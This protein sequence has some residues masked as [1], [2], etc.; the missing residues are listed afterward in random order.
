MSSVSGE[1]LV[2]EV[3]CPFRNVN[4]LNPMGFNQTD[5]YNAEQPALFL[6]DTG[7][8]LYLWQ[9]FWPPSHSP[10]DNSN[11]ITG[12]GMIRWHAERRAA[13]ATIVQYRKLSYKDFRK[14]PDAELVWA[15]CEPDKFTNLFPSWTHKPEVEKVNRE[16]VKDN[17]LERTLSELSKSEYTWEELQQRPLPDGVDPAK[18]EKYLSDSDFEKYLKVSREDFNSAPWWKQIE[19]RKDRGL[20]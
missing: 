11:T 4:V 5:L 10:E 1:F 12:S 8:N 7:S 20:F 3:L 6:L 2:T 16:F 13:M 19:I 15:G 18:L 14:L 17:S 9:G